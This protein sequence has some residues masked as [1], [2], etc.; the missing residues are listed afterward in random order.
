VLERLNAFATSQTGNTIDETEL[1]AWTRGLNRGED[2]DQERLRANPGPDITVLTAIPQIRTHVALRF[3]EK[4]AKPPIFPPAVGRRSFP[5][6]GT[7]RIF[8]TASLEIA[9]PLRPLTSRKPP[10]QFIRINFRFPCKLS[11]AKLTSIERTALTGSFP[12][13]GLFRKGRQR[14]TP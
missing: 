3:G 14:K 4:A 13:N 1:H 6:S 8:R 7:T 11:C 12:L 5:E 2:K 9:N 10:I